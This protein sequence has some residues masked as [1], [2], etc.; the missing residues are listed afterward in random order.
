MAQVYR[1]NLDP[2]FVDLKSR[3]VTRQIAAATRLADQATAAFRA[4][5]A[6]QRYT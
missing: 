6:G 5:L 1:D 2:H 3:D 4:H